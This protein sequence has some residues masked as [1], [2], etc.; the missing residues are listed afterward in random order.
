MTRPL[1][2]STCPPRTE[3]TSSWPPRRPQ[4]KR[5]LDFRQY[6]R[7]LAA[8]LTLAEA[9]ERRRVAEGLHDQVGPL[10]T[11]AGMRLDAIEISTGRPMAEVRDL[12]RQALTEI[13]DLTF[14]LRAPLLESHGIAAALR[15]LGSRWQKQHGLVCQVKTA[16]ISLDGIPLQLTE[17]WS[18]FLLRAAR[19]LLWN[20]VKH[21]SARRVVVSLERHGKAVTLRV[22]DDGGGFAPREPLRTTSEGGFGLPELQRRAEQLGGRLS[23]ETSD[24]GACVQIAAPLEMAASAWPTAV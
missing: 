20:I 3:P 15:D 18:V 14:D 21:A 1:Q 16:D 13:R 10:L 9:K 24:R 23:I 12:V 19:E 17:E 7:Q 22:Q 5:A 2:S 4:G 11:L 6:R 8:D